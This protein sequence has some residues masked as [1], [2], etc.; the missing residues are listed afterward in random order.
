MRQNVQQTRIARR[1][2]IPCLAS[3]IKCD[4]AVLAAFERGDDILPDDVQSR[5]VKQ[6]NL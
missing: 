4:V 5:L 1:L 6:L 2:S 3:L